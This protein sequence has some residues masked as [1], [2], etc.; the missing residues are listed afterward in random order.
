[1]SVE[2]SNSYPKHSCS[3]SAVPWSSIL[4]RRAPFCCAHL[5]SLLTQNTTGASASFYLSNRFHLL[6]LG[7]WL[8]YTLLR[9]YGYKTFKSH[10]KHEVLTRNR[11]YSLPQT[12]AVTARVRPNK[13]T[14]LGIFQHITHSNPKLTIMQDGSFKLLPFKTRKSPHLKMFV[15]KASKT[16]SWTAQKTAWA[17]APL[18]LVCVSWH[19]ERDCCAL[20]SPVSGVLAGGM[21]NKWPS[22]KAYRAVV[23]AALN[24]PPVP[25]CNKTTSKNLSKM[26]GMP[27]RWDQKY[28]NKGIPWC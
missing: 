14:S 15:H 10:K 26:E 19:K 4:S 7:N 22:N 25:D 11:Y 27:Y 20:Y 5:R 9:N 23:Q 2:L 21:K 16:G 24:I 12:V 6:P 18:W 3:I 13:A 17:G 1:M 8:L 28:H